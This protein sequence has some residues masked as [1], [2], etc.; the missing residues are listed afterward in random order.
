MKS[1]YKVNIVGGGFVG[2]TLAEVLSHQ[3]SVSSVVVIDTD[4][5]KIDRLKAGDIPVKEKDLTLKSKRI[6]YTT[7]IKDSEGDV[8]FVCVGTPD[9]GD[10]SQRL[11]SLRD[12]IKSIINHNVRSTIILKSTTTP[13]NIELVES[14]ID[15][16]LTKFIVNPEFL[17]EGKAVED[18]KNQPQLVVGASERDS[19]YAEELMSN[20]FKGTYDKLALVSTKEAMMI[21]YFLN[22]YKAM[23]LTFIN[24]V[25]AYCESSGM[26][27]KK[28]MNSIN[29]PVLGT[30]FD[31]PGVG[32]GGSCFPK[33][34]HALG[35]HMLLAR[36]V[37]GVNNSLIHSFAESLVESVPEGPMLFIGKSFKVSTN[38]TRESVSVKVHDYI[39]SRDPE[40]RIYFYDEDPTLSDLTEDEVLEHKSEFSAIVMFNEYPELAKN[41]EDMDTFINTRKVL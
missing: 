16:I 32:F 28:I 38:D 5:C 8:Y 19:K 29:D 15:P 40:C 14:W 39:R 22:T 27:F 23:K 21:K 31:K 11:E 1:A 35:Q 18:L 24:S 13:E 4:E 3:S 20:L 17:A 30:G 33:D 41:L 7:D 26:S 36:C 34:T 12:A 25:N 2:L 6:K 37:Y 10:G 9:S